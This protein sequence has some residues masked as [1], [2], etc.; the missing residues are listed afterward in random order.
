MSHHVSLMV[1]ELCQRKAYFLKLLPQRS[2]MQFMGTFLMIWF[3]TCLLDY[4]CLIPDYH[5]A[6]LSFRHLLVNLKWFHFLST[7]WGFKAFIKNRWRVTGNGGAKQAEQ[8]FQLI[9]S[10]WICSGPLDDNQQKIC[11]KDLGNCSVYC[12]NGTAMIMWWL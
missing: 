6:T 10:G 12:L 2:R 5:F 3:G 1:Y 9:S 7:F 8:H 11:C 4:L